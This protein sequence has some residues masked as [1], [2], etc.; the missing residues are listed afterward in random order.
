MRAGRIVAIVFGVL[1][2][3]VGFGMGAG[4]SVLVWAHATQRDSAG[5]YETSTERFDTPTYALTS[6]IDLGALPG[7]RD[8]TIAHPVGTV[9]V[10]AG[11]VDNRPVF[12]GIAPKSDVDRWLA[13]VPHDHVTASNFESFHG[14][15]Q[16]TGGEGA[17]GRPAAQSFWV[18]SKSGAGRQTVRWPSASGQWTIVVMNADGARNVSVDV[19]AGAK[20]GVLL[21]IG[22]GLGVVG[23]LLI[24]GGVALLLFGVRGLSTATP[25]AGPAAPVPATTPPPQGAASL[26]SGLPGRGWMGTWTSRSAGGCGS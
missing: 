11:A 23:L 16:S 26:G 15:R 6:Q 13:G 1:V 8:W 17:P 7:G 3:L 5:F 10:R 14:D 22:I 19:S 4:G 9:R 12:I 21:P 20:T 2:T 25:V 24:G 18:A